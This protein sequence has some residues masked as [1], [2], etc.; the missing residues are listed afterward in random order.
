MSTDA[1][2]LDYD[3]M[4][5]AK[6]HTYTLIT[7]ANLKFYRQKKQ[8]NTQTALQITITSQGTKKSAQN[9][10]LGDSTFKKRIQ[11][12]RVYIV[13]T[14]EADR[15]NMIWEFIG[16]KSYG[17]SVDGIIEEM[18]QAENNGMVYEVNHV[19]NKHG[20]KNKFTGLIEIRRERHK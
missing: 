2:N 3:V 9:T 13:A 16:D 19:T 4:V 8:I 6:A 15:D 14:K 20:S 10:T 11:D 17:G 1:M 18:N 5:A 7:K 12:C